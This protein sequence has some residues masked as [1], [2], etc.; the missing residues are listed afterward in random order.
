MNKF[1]FE[2]KIEIELYLLVMPLFPLA[3]TRMFYKDILMFKGV[4]LY[5][6]SR[7]VLILLIGLIFYKMIKSTFSIIEKCTLIKKK[8]IML[9]IIRQ[10]SFYIY[11][12]VYMLY[13][14]I[15]IKLA[16]MFLLIFYV[17]MYYEL[18]RKLFGVMNKK[19][20]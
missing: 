20:N 5:G 9:S 8:T 3:I 16:Y 11:I 17:V 6:F 10:K 2:N 14:I 13:C 12:I 1:T 15:R 7:Y 4:V 18:L 19:N